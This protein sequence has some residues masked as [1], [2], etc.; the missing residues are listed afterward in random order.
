MSTD[1]IIVLKSLPTEMTEQIESICQDTGQTEVDV[2]V[3]L[4]QAALDTITATTR[5]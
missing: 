3:Q 1:N 2:I 4:I 5:E